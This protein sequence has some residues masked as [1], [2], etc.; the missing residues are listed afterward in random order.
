MPNLNPAH[1]HQKNSSA[2]SRPNINFEKRAPD[3]EDFTGKQIIPR[4]SFQVSFCIRA[5]RTD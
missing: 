1:S 2:H 5:G 3:N 4:T